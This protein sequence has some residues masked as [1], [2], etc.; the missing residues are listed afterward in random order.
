MEPG[1]SMRFM[2]LRNDRSYTKK[3]F[4]EKLSVSGT[5]ISDIENGKREPSK[6]LLLKAAEEFAVSL[7]WLYLGLGPKSLFDSLDP[8]KGL[9]PNDPFPN[10][11][12]GLA[13]QIDEYSAPDKPEDGQATVAF[14]KRLGSIEFRLGSIEAAL[15]RMTGKE[16]P[17]E[18]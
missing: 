12:P 2:E 4:A 9:D 11:F 16:P 10:G 18:E 1:V 6:E 14:E 7:N 13:G 8:F 5:I 15:Q 3:E 17:K